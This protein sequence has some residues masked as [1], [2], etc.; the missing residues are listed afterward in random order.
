MA[1]V[2]LH[3]RNDTNEVFYVGIGNTERRA[4][5]KSSR[6]KYWKNIVQKC[7]Y[8]ITI[9]HKD[10][11]WEEACSIEK[12]LI[13]FYKQYGKSLVNKNEGGEG[14]LGYVFSEESRKK[15][16]ESGKLAQNNPDTKRKRIESLKKYYQ[17]PEARE[18]NRQR[19]IIAYS[20]EEARSRNRKRQL[21][22]SVIEKKILAAKKRFA[23]QEYRK[24]LGETQKIVQN[25]PEVQEKRR[26]SLI[27]AQNR[28]STRLKRKESIKKAIKEGRLLIRRTQI[29]Q[30]M[31]NG[32]FVKKWGSIKEAADSLGIFPQNISACCR[33]VSSMCK[34]FKWEYA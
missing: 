25:L 32:S 22:P 30:L 20:S 12:Y 11:S 18:K 1:I 19:Q 5:S 34:N 4:Y 9:T 26:K 33:G 14:N 28:L 6:N 31:L 13:S 27:I 7:N 29:N 17:S 16:S 23:S 10:I 15:I 2:Y 24:K 21:L 3:R 8:T